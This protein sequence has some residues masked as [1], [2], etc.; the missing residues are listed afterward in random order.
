LVLV[1]GLD[2]IV[3]STDWERGLFNLYN[4]LKQ[5]AGSLVLASRRS[6]KALDIE[7]PDLKS[8][9]L[10]CSVFALGELSDEGKGRA[11]SQVAESRGIQL[12]PEISHYLITR[13]PRDMHSLFAFLDE[14][15][16]RSLQ[17][18]R[19]LTIPFIKSVLEAR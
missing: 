14:L 2:F 1:D 18:Q 11:L 13:L 5:S 12:S 19:K 16:R 9:L 15:D 7:L 17:L 10:G 8:R 3:G 4:Q 6:P